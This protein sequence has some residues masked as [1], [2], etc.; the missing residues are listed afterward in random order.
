MSNY[1]VV[2]YGPRDGI[3]PHWF[4]PQRRVFLFFWKRI[5]PNVAYHQH[6]EAHNA[7]IEHCNLSRCKF[8]NIH[9]YTL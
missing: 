7:C 1:R 5:N 9:E 4:I 3:R 6:F 8:W 2:S